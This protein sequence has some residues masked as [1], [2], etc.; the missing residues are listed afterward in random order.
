MPMQRNFH[1]EVIAS[2]EAWWRVPR[3]RRD[4]LIDTLALTALIVA[5]VLAATWVAQP[6]LRTQAAANDSNRALVGFWPAEQNGPD[7]FRWSRADSAVRLFGFEQQA[8]VVVRLRLTAVRQP[9]QS[10][11]VL[12]VGGTTQLPP[13]VVQPLV[14]RRYSFILPAPQRGDEAPLL[15]LHTDDPELFDRA[16]EALEGAYFI[17]PEG[18]R[19]DLLPLVID[20]IG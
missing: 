15:T 19:P 17:A 3:P 20:R 6:Q 14:W 18:S 1:D 8:P 11:A 5:I 9:G 7:T 2:T 10:P 12:T 4:W 13:V 16:L